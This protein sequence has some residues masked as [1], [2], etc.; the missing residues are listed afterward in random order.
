MKRH[1]FIPL[2][3][4]LIGIIFGCLLVFNSCEPKPLIKTKIEQKQD[5]IKVITKI[6]EVEKLK[7]IPI[8]HKSD[9]LSDSIIIYKELHDTIRIVMLQDSLINNQQLE[10]KQLDSII[11]FLDKQSQEQKDVIDLQ[12]VHI[13]D[14]ENDN[15]D[16]RKQVRKGKVK[17]FI[18]GA[19]GVVVG[20]LVANLI[21]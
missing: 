1:E 20:Y 4:I 18:I 3:I 14:I 8:K 15:K 13:S 6:V 11:F 21:K 10:I 12:E 19:G 16:L 17:G 5:E 7:Y 9:G 2:L